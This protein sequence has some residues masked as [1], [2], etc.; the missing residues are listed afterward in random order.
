MGRARRRYAPEQVI[1]KLKVADRL[2][3]EGLGVAEVAKRLEVSERTLRRWR[4][5]Y[6]GSKAGDATRL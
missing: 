2:L 6:D 4:L 1:R 5:H 3:G